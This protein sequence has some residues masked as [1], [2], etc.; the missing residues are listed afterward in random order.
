MSGRFTD[1]IGR[2][3]SAVAAWVTSPKSAVTASANSKGSSVGGVPD[4]WIGVK[5]GD[6][7]TAEH[8]FPCIGTR[9]AGR[10]WHPVGTNTQ[11]FRDFL[12]PHFKHDTEWQHMCSACADHPEEVQRWRNLYDDRL[13]EQAV[14]RIEE[15]AAREAAAR[16]AAASEAAARSPASAQTE[17]V[18]GRSVAMTV[19]AAAEGPA[20]QT[21]TV[22]R[23]SSA[24][25]VD[26]SADGNA[27]DGDV[28]S[29]VES[30]DSEDEEGP[31]T[32]AARRSMVAPGRQ[33]SAACIYLVHCCVF[34]IRFRP[35][36]FHE[37]ETVL[38]RRKI[39]WVMF[40]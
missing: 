25:P 6:R 22:Q 33:S 7:F 20:A 19:D 23:S 32:K 8:P 38:W 4:D 10:E 21:E 13:V 24:M 30:S 11:G 3:L 18:H 35:V 34:S 29:G 5:S 15:V 39:K 2:G 27:S 12:E 1:S 9:C 14:D 16:E 36:C 17:M 26:E 37:F 31:L 28:P 40:S